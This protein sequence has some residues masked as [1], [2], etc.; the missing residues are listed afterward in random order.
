WGNGQERVPDVVPSPERRASWSRTLIGIIEGWIPF[1]RETQRPTR[2]GLLRPTQARPQHDNYEQTAPYQPTRLHMGLLCMDTLSHEHTAQ[3][4]P[5]PGD[6]TPQQ[7]SSIEPGSNGSLQLSSV[8]CCF[9]VSSYY[10]WLT[11][12]SA[13]RAHRASRHRRG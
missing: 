9:I 1:Q 4:Y 11:S 5:K 13:G 12:S 3:R 2:P 8:P 6:H 10:L 7:L